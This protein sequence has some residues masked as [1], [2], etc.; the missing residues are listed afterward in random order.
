[1][2][3]TLDLQKSTLA[4]RPSLKGRISLF[5]PPLIYLHLFLSF[6]VYILGRKTK[7]KL[8]IAH[9]SVDD[10]QSSHQGYGWIN[11]PLSQ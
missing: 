1:M 5:H 2:K 10:G 4:R 6:L 7:R 9:G 11:V 8:A 3:Q